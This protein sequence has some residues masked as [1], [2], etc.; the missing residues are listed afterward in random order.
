MK[1][2]VHGG[3]WAGYR[4]R[5]G[6][7]ALDFSAN[8]SP[9]GLPAGV[10]KAITV[11]LSTADRY[12]DP[13]CRE[14]RARLAKEEQVQAEQILCGNGAADL[15]FRLVLAAKP[16][17]ALLPAPT[18][19]EYAAALETVNCEI[20][21]HILQEAKDF[22]LTETFLDEI[23]ETVDMVFLCQPNNPTGQLTELSRVRE[24]LNRCQTCGAILVVDECFLDFLQNSEEYSAKALLD[25]K[26]LVIL[27][28]FTKLYGMAGVRLGYCLSSDGALLAQMQSCGQPWAVS[29]LAQAAGIAALDET[30][31]VS[32]VRE[33]IEQQRPVLTEGLRAFGLRVLE[34]KA[35]YLLLQASETLGDTLREKGVVLRSCA[36][37]IGLD[38]SWYRTAVRTEAE[39]QQLLKTLSEVLR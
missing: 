3:D 4:E 21:R 13:L 31:Y 1:T 39:N 24:I 18:F 38:A 22:V 16:K 32:Q 26:N 12:P 2:L 14:L 37:Y 28:A 27:K 30:E 15:I 33:L 29:S 7:D 20:K 34:G 8:V 5:F 10:A 6:R 25:A 17:K 19:A 35:N 23:D 11:A 36:N 9:L